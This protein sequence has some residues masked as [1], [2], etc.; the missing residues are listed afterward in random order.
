MDLEVIYGDL[1]LANEQY[2]AHQCNCVTTYAAG[3]AKAI[4]DKY[5][6]ANTYKLRTCD[7]P[8]TSQINTIGIHGNG[9]D[10]RY[11]INMYA[12]VYPGSPKYLNSKLDGTLAR[13]LYFNNCLQLIAKINKIESIAFPFKIGCN[14]GGGDWLIYRKMIKMFAE[15]NPNIKIRVYN[16]QKD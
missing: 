14:L 6:Y 16:K 9:S 3:A 8:D 4:F 13:Q 7:K 2:I 15:Q 10:E 12:Q 11:I 5:P 1:L